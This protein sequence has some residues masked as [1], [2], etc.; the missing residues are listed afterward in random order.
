MLC[1]NCSG[2]RVS[3][4][5]RRLNPKTP[6]PIPSELALLGSIVPKTMLGIR[7]VWSRRVF[8]SKGQHSVYVRVR[9]GVLLGLR[10]ARVSYRSHNGRAHVVYIHRYGCLRC[11][12]RWQWRSDQPYQAP[13]IPESP[14][15]A[16]THPNGTQQ[17]AWE[18]RK[19]R[20]E[21]YRS[22]AHS[23]DL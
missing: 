14:V 20:Q 8:P 6:V 7:T 19:E 10:A 9:Y 1:P 12:Y 23:V 17:P 11:G 5:R 15:P 18:E 3:D 13:F 21:S 16:Q 22:L 2:K 4:A